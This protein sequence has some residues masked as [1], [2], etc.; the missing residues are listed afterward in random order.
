MRSG[1]LSQK[2]SS[3]FLPVGKEARLVISQ[4]DTMMQSSD[5]ALEIL[6]LHDTGKL[7][8]Y[9]VIFPEPSSAIYE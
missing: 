4:A 8:F 7:I 6:I 3:P 1:T 9:G 5:A 2:C